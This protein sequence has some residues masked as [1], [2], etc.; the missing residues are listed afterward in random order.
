MAYG[1]YAKKAKKMGRKPLR[2]GARRPRT[3]VKK[4]SADVRLLKRKVAG[5]KKTFTDGLIVATPVGQCNVNANSAWTQDMTPRPPSGTGYSERV[6]RSIKLVS[7]SVQYQISQ[8]VNCINPMNI[9]IYIVR[10]VGTPVTANVAYD[11]FKVVNPITG[12][13]DSMSTRDLNYFKDYRVLKKINVY[14]K[15]DQI[16]GGQSIV[17]G[18]VNM[19]LNQ[20]INFDEDTTTVTDGQLCMFAYASTG[21]S[22]ATNSTLPNVINQN[23]AS[24]AVIQTYTKFWYEDN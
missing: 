17:T 14:L 20:Y 21:N 3:A 9:E 8:Q 6:G 4:L 10:I 12:V 2:K 22:G 7:M 16:S 24:G 11:N 18:R 1:N 19:K 5:E 13:K 23:Y 15:Q